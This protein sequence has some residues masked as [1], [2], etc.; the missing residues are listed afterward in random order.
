M[1]FLIWRTFNFRFLRYRCLLLK[2]N[3]LHH[4]APRTTA[5]WTLH[6]LSWRAVTS[7]RCH[8]QNNFLHHRAPQTA[9]PWT[10]HH[11]PCRAVTSYRCHHLENNKSLHHRAHQTAVHI[12]WTMRWC[13][14]QRAMWY[15]WIIF[16]IIYYVVY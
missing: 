14:V 6:H 9:A 4:R 5:T 15:I 11:Q 1:N 8:L 2:N 13:S 10:L 16:I 7:Y 3:I 12:V